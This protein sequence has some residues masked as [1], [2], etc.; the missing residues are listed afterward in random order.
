GGGIR[1]DGELYLIASTVADNEAVRGGG[2]YST[3]SIEL[4]DEAVVGGN[5][6]AS[7]GGGVYFA[8][9]TGAPRLV[10][11]GGST[12]RGN[13]AGLDGGGVFSEGELALELCPSRLVEEN[14]A[15]GGTGGG[16]HAPD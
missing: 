16:I 5:V 14:R 3:S 6:A 15:E 7:S 8:E 9:G 12:V 2:V 11:V 1:N 4:L 10:L 13:V